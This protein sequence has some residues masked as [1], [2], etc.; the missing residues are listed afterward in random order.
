M[1]PDEFERVGRRM[2]EWIADYMRRVESLPVR[3]NAAPGAVAASLPETPPDSPGGEDAW[4][5]I[6]DDLRRIIEPGLTH[7]QSPGFFGYFPANATGPAILAELLSA[8]LGVQG[9]LWSTSPACTE[10]ETRMMDWLARA[11][12]LPESFLS[13]S[14]DAGGVI[15]GT[16]SEAALVALVAARHAVG[17]SD[18]PFRVY[19]SSQAHSSIVKAAMIAGLGRESVRLVE[20]DE[21]YAMKPDALARAIDADRDAGEIPLFVCAT[22]GTTSSTAID[23]VGPIGEVCAARGVW[24]HVDAA[25]AGAATVCPEHRW[26]LEGVERADT[27]NFNPHKWM[28][29]NFDCSALWTRRRETLVGALSITPEYLRNRASDAGA[30]IDYRDWQIPLGRRFRALK[31]WFV[32]RHYGVDGI[33][34]HIR[35]GVDLARRFED[36]VRSDDR[37]EV[38]APRPLSLVCFRLRGGDEVNETLLEAVNASGEVLLTHTKLPTPSGERYTLRLAVGGV[39]TEMEHVGRA[40]SLIRQGA[41]RLV[42]AAQPAGGARTG[43]SASRPVA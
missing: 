1:T 3:G 12:G 22:V 43:P 19:A 8:G 11:C 33:R 16:A 37:F 30:V 41:D 14:P 35:K 13:T 26:L 7:W 36:L 17:D 25:Y 39:R 20:V 23:P 42:G 24:L 27:Y 38:A 40:C 5:G 2:V 29:T 6:F 15:Q 31:L 10:V 9:M 34:A 32:L 28:L 18:G 4:D 21:D